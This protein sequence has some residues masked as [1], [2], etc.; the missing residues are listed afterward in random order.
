[1]GI[2][3]SGNRK[4]LVNPCCNSER[5]HKF[6][7]REIWL[8]KGRNN[9]FLTELKPVVVQNRRALIPMKEDSRMTVERMIQEGCPMIWLPEDGSIRD[10][11]YTKF[12]EINESKNLPLLDNLKRESQKATKH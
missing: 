10:I 6:I 1:M 4:A 11:I 3:R 5:I 12:D 7:E 9:F 8:A 2:L